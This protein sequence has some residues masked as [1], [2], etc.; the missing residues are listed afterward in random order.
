MFFPATDS[1]LREAEYRIRVCAEKAI[2]LI[3]SHSSVGIEQAVFVYLME[4]FDRLPGGFFPLRENISIPVSSGDLLDAK[5]D[6]H[7]DPMKEDS[8]IASEFSSSFDTDG[9]VQVEPPP[10]TPLNEKLPLGI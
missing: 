10:A 6:R 2:S 5:A 8:V 4:N 1:A 3:G 9:E 7:S